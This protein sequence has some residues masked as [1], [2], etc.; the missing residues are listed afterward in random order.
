ME[1]EYLE[2]QWSANT[3]LNATGVNGQAVDVE[4]NTLINWV[5]KRM[6]R[7]CHDSRFIIYYWL[8][9]FRG[10]LR[11]WSNTVTFH[12]FL[13]KVLSRQ[14]KVSYVSNFYYLEMFCLPFEHRNLVFAESK[15]VHIF[16]FFFSGINNRRA[17]FWQ[18]CEIAMLIFGDFSHLPSAFL[19][20]FS[21]SSV[22]HLLSCYNDLPTPEPQPP[23]L[24]LVS[25]ISILREFL[26]NSKPSRHK[27]MQDTKE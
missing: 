7:S 13:R 12:W 3:I 27:R 10:K 4:W 20:H 16:F 15:L 14:N 9:H 11:R 2:I 5:R 6:I 24:H 19:F 25:D 23:H 21:D 1:I 17:G 26:K 18:N 8:S 22:L